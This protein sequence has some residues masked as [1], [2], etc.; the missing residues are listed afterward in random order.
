M[1][2]DEFVDRVIVAVMVLGLMLL[3]ALLLLQ[4]QA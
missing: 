3:A 2:D 1:S 4:A